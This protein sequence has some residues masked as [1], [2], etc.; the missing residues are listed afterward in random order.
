MSIYEIIGFL[1][2]VMVLISFT[3]TDVKRIRILNCTGCILFVI[4]GILISAWSVW[5]VNLIIVGTH[6][7]NI[8]KLKRK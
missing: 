5:V 4:Y 2:G 1:A 7:Y 6:I 8:R 3:Q